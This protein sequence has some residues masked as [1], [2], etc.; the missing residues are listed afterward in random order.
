M[1]DACPWGL[2][3]MKYPAES[4]ATDMPEDQAEKAFDKIKDYMDKQD[5]TK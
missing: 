3:N 2:E 4:W 1:K 5:K